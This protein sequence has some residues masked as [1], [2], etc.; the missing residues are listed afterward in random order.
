MSIQNLGQGAA[1]AIDWSGPSRQPCPVC[2]RGLKDKSCGV[3]VGSDGNGVAHCFRC[4]YVQTLH[5]DRAAGLRGSRRYEKQSTKHR[6]TLSKYGQDLWAE[7]I[8]IEGVALAYLKARQC[9]IPPSAGHLRF[10]PNLKHW[11]SGS[12][13]PALVALVTD[14][15]TREPMTLHR[16]WVQAD[17]SK[18][19]IDP[20]RMLLKDH[21]KVGG[22][23][24]LWPDEE[25]TT[26]LGIGEGIETTLSLAHAFTPAWAL[27]DAG[28]LAA[29]P[30]LD[31]VQ[32]LLIAAD[33]DPP[34]IAAANSC[35]MRWAGQGREVRIVLPETP[36]SDLNDL[37]RSA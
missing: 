33:N 24:R 31:G 37:A 23:V 3:T 5:G 17:G 9:V 10:H 18:A 15:V 19:Q 34:G 29:M 22:V 21:G 25:V 28:N 36:R 12:A 20:A 1:L 4:G 13:G 16:T 6:P 11:P 26:S 27:I 32:S 7:C 35:A 30:L 8:Q 14:A 2:G